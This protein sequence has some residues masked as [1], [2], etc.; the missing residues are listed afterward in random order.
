MVRPSEAIRMME[1]RGRSDPQ[2]DGSEGETKRDASRHRKSGR[3]RRDVWATAKR[4]PSDKTSVLRMT[5][6]V[7]AQ[8]GSL[9]LSRQKAPKKRPNDGYPNTTYDH[10]YQFISHIGFSDLLSDGDTACRGRYRA[11]IKINASASVKHSL[12]RAFAARCW[13]LSAD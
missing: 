11:A 10:C 3:K 7:S 12:R 5:A 4:D 13:R 2:H 9:Q 8:E 6:A 1:Q